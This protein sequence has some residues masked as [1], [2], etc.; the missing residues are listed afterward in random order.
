[1]RVN[2]KEY[3]DEKSVVVRN[4]IRDLN[5]ATNPTEIKEAQGRLA[6]IRHDNRDV[7]DVNRYM[8]DVA[9]K[10]SDIDKEVNDFK[11]WTEGIN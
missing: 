4:I 2:Q 11:N 8:N 5:S 3:Q 10:K 9:A 1:V 6:N 7:A